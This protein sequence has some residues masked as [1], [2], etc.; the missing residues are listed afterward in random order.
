MPTGIARN[1]HQQSTNSINEYIYFRPAKPREHGKPCGCA[2]N[3]HTVLTDWITTPM[4]DSTEFIAR[5]Y[6]SGEGHRVVYSGGVIESIEPTEA[7]E[8][9]WYGP[10]IFDPQVNGYAGIDF[11]QDDLSAEELHKASSGL[12]A[13]GCPRWLLTLI[14]DDFSK[15][16]ARLAHL[17]KLRDGDP[18]LSKAIAGWHV[19]GPFLS[20]EPGF[21]GAHNPAVM[22][23]PTIADIDQLREVLGTDPILLTIAPERE[24][25]T[26]VIERAVQLGIRVSMGH[27]NPS[28][29]NLTQARAAG[30]TGF[31]HLSNACPQQLDRHDNFLWRVLDSGNLTC[32]LIP[33]KIHVR[34]MLFRIF[35]RVLDPENIYYTTD[36]MSAAGAPPGRYTVGWLDIEVGEDQIVRQP[37][38]TNLAGSALRPIQGVQRVAEMLGQPWQEV[39]DGFS[40]RPAKYMGINHQLEPGQ[41]AALCKI[42]TDPSGQLTEIEAF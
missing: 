25:S 29:E 15:L 5:H 31:T 20:T 39:W 23:D 16:I 34:P 32:G 33:D 26:A 9:T 13:D 7:P 1:F 36:A 4:A 30:A 38:K 19:E 40:V 24:G 37:G 27:C 6:Q 35:H 14:T 10:G 8:N 41:S 3:R 18:V 28:S 11:Q 42:T 22:R 2:Q 21:C 12:K 17:K